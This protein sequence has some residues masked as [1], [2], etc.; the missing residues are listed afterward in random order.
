MLFVFNDFFGDLLPPKHQFLKT[1][2]KYGIVLLLMILLAWYSKWIGYGLE[3]AWGQLKIVYRAQPVEVFLDDPNFP[4]S[5]KQKIELVQEVRSFAIENLG[6]NDSKNYKTLYDM[7]GEEVL[8]VITAC[9]PFKLEAKTWD[10]PIVGGMEYMGFFNK[11]K[12]LHERNVLRDQGWDATIST[13]SAWSTLGLFR[14]PILSKNLAR[15]KGSLANL[16]IHE[17]THSTLYVKDSVDFNENLATF[18]GDRGAREFLKS[19]FGGGSMEYME[20]VKEIEDKEKF[21]LHMLNGTQKLDSL[22]NTFSENDSL[23]F[24]LKEK[25]LMIKSIIQNLDTVQFHNPARYQ[26]VIQA[27]ILYNT[28][29]MRFLRY[30]GNQDELARELDNQFAGDLKAYL[31]FL[32]EKYPSL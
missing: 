30:E 11:Q 4:D 19:R 18:I 32:K 24:K 25:K 22:Y 28:Y 17:L 6:I 9:Q 23:D 16:I 14:D 26:K 21:T 31:T 29:F 27:K 8:W 12:A 10:Y 7:K 20:Y 15:S 5:L 1:K 3:Q 13:P 2:L